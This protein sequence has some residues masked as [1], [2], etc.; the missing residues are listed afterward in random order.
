[1]T[2]P[3]AGIPWRGSEGGGPPLAA[4]WGTGDGEVCGEPAGRSE[5]AE[6]ASGTEGG[7]AGLEPT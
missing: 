1:M 7:S 3:K 5:E 4:G 2:E 6:G